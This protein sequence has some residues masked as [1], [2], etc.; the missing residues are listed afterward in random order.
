MK[1]MT[2]M[3]NREKKKTMNNQYPKKKNLKKNTNTPRKNNEQQRK[4]WKTA[5]TVKKKTQGKQ[6]P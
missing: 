2:N 1:S 5:K 4:L 6:K 3:K